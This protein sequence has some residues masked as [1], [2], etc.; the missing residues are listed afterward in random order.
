MTFISSSRNLGGTKAFANNG[1]RGLL[2]ER[3]KLH[4]NRMERDL[5]SDF[6]LASDYAMLDEKPEAL[7]YLRLACAKREFGVSTLAVNPEL[8]NLHGDPALEASWPVSYSQLATP[9]H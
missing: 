1:I 7:H 5:A 4:K 8:A 6:D 9:S 2:Q 3:L